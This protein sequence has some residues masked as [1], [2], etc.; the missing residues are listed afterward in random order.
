MTSS[1]EEDCQGKQFLHCSYIT[2][3]K[4]KIDFF[5]FFRLRKKKIKKIENMS[6]TKVPTLVFTKTKN[7]SMVYW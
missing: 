5:F 6:H 1:T 7:L 4:R 2:V 3:T